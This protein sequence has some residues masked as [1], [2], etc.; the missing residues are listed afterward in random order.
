[1][2][3]FTFKIIKIHIEQFL[4][5]QIFWSISTPGA[6]ATFYLRTHLPAAYAVGHIGKH[7]CVSVSLN[8]QHYLCVQIRTRLTR[9][10]SVRIHFMFARKQTSTRKIYI[11]I[12]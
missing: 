7:T 6:V 12:L 3:I 8:L 10:N 11:N 1:M 9:A 5:E 4:A 2:L